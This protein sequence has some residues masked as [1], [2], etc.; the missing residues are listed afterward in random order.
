MMDHIAGGGKCRTYKMAG[1]VDW[2][3]RDWTIQDLENKRP[4]QDFLPMTEYY[5]CVNAPRSGIALVPYGHTTFCAACEDILTG[6]GSNCPVC[7][8]R[9]T[10]FCDRTTKNFTVLASLAFVV[11]LCNCTCIRFIMARSA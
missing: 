8:S 11:Q 6:M 1:Y 4:N 9:M 2:N 7:R 5:N 3:V 10:W